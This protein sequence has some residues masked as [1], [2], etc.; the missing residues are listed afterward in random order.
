MLD[1]SPS[2]M[3]IEFPAKYFKEGTNLLEFKLPDARKPASEDSR[4]VGLALQEMVF[5]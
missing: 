1:G 2:N 4:V 5:E 3:K